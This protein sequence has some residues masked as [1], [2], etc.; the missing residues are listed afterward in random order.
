M[1]TDYVFYPVIGESSFSGLDAQSGTLTF[2]GGDQVKVKFNGLT[3]IEG[4]DYSI[5]LPSQSVT[6]VEP[7]A[8]DSTN[9]VQGHVVISVHHHPVFVTPV[10]PVLNNA[11][12]RLGDV[13][14]DSSDPLGVK[15]RVPGP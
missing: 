13:W 14:I 9:G 3:L 10:D 8:K 1:M 12:V 6:L 15:V 2:N 4:V 7:V 5:D 11:E